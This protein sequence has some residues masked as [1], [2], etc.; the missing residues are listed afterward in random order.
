MASASVSTGTS[1]GPDDC[2][3]PR[4]LIYDVQFSLAQLRSR[5]ERAIPLSRRTRIDDALLTNAAIAL[6]NLRSALELDRTRKAARSSRE[7][8]SQ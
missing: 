1:P 4:H 5:L 3:L 6:N 2:V 7:R 8:N